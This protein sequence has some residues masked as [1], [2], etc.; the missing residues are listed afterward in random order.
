LW[1]ELSHAPPLRWEDDLSAATDTALRVYRAFTE[2]F[3][4]AFMR[5]NGCGEVW[6]RRCLS[7]ALGYTPEPAVEAVLHRIR[8]LRPRLLRSFC[9]KYQQHLFGP[10]TFQPGG[11]HGY[12]RRVA[13][14]ESRKAPLAELHRVVGMD[15]ECLDHALW[16]ETRPTE[17]QDHGHRA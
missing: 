1:R 15:P 14:V 3:D 5:E 2:A 7:R 8:D 4:A 6:V 12:L 16:P 11:V 17:G 9:K 10:L 13:Q